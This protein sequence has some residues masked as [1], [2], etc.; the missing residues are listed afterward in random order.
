[1]CTEVVLNYYD[2]GKV[3][4]C[5]QAV[6]W[7]VQ[8]FCPSVRLSIRLSQLFNY[9][10]I[11][12]ST[13]FQELLPMKEVMSMQKVKVRGQRSRWL[14]SKH[15]LA[16]SGPQLQ[17]EFTYDDEVIHEALCSLGKVPYWF[18]RSSIKFQGHIAKKFVDFD[19]NWVF[20]HCNSSLNSLMAMEWS[21]MLE[22]TWKMCLI[23]FQGCQSNFKVTRDKKMTNFDLNGAHL[24][25]NS[26]LNSPMALKQCTKLE[27]A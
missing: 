17:F 9:G 3:F 16:V 7:M 25:C 22:A 6:L 27:V 15:N 2:I 1:M 24:D 18:S 8:F 12:S 5:D 4:S 14:R 19:P 11:V 10:L 26:N 13:N 21:T 23:V 20:P